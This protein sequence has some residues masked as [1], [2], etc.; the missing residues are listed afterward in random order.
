[1]DNGKEVS[2]MEKELFLLMITII[3]EFGIKDKE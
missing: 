1:M 3:K 2:S